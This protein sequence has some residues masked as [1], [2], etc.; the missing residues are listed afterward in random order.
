MRYVSPVARQGGPTEMPP[1]LLGF[2]RGMIGRAACFFAGAPG[3][4]GV[5]GRIFQVEFAA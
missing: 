1:G 5:D 3:F 2:P 4:S